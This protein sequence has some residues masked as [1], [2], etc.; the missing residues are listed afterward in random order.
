M[1]VSSEASG[2]T[3]SGLA[4]MAWETFLSIGPSG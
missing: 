1:T 3:V 2:W 4:L